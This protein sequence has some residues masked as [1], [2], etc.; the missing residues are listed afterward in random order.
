MRYGE[1]KKEGRRRR[2]VAGEEDSE[3]ERRRVP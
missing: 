3:G 2:W 1:R